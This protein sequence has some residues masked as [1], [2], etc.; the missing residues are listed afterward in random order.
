MARI[1]VNEIASLVGQVANERGGFPSHNG[2]RSTCDQWVALATRES[3]DGRTY[4][5]TTIRGRRQCAPGQYPNGLWQFCPNTLDPATANDPVAATR[6]AF[7][8]YEQ[9]GWQPWAASHTPTQESIVACVEHGGITHQAGPSD[10]FDI[11]RGLVTNPLEAVQL[12]IES[13]TSTFS[14]I[15]E[16]F[17]RIGK[18]VTDRHNW[19]RIAMVV[20]GLG[21][22]AIGVNLVI[23][24]TTGVDSA[25]V[26]KTVATKGLA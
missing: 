12:A 7:E 17:N 5:D 23:Q 6:K 11:T 20:G 13:L 9:R 4:G 14:A 10:A 2:R 3:G 25:K 15:I 8:L 18:W 21:V 26:V 19:V 16:F 24:R 22:G 1:S